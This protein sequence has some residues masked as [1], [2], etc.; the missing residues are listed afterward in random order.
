MRPHFDSLY[1]AARR[2]AL[3]ADDADDLLQ[4]VFITAFDRLDEL[5]SV[6]HRRAWLLTVMYNRFIDGR[7]RESRSPLGNSSTGDDS[8]EPDR[9]PGA[10][11]GPE[12]AT[13]SELKLSRLLD[14]MRCL[15]AD[16]CTLLAMHDVEGFT[17]DELCELTGAPAGTVKSRLHRTRV[18]LGRLL[19]NPAIGR[20]HL[21]IVGKT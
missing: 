1:R 9:M 10:T 6:E 15:D 8:V 13:E 21:R 19:K 3:R 11:A 4:D 17:I 12:Q 20:R 16:S 14:A 5:R 7:R 18:K 2:L